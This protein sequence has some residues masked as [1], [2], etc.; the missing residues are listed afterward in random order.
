MRP[1]C[2]P[3]DA[4]TH[5]CSRSTSDQLTWQPRARGSPSR[6]HWKRV[7]ERDR[8]RLSHSHHRKRPGGSSP[9]LIRHTPQLTGEYLQRTLRLGLDRAQEINNSPDRQIPKQI[10]AMG[11]ESLKVD[12]DGFWLQH[13]AR[14]TEAIKS[15]Q[16]GVQQAAALILM[17]GGNV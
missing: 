10:W 14:L 12:R 11:D 16:T 3:N 6:T 13:R 8:L 1:S 4:L 2:N 7:C 15:G 9:I 5:F 17:A